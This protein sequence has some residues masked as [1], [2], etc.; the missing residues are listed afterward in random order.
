MLDKTRESDAGRQ[1]Q[2]AR[3]EQL[4]HATITAIAEHGLSNVT[5]S[6]VARKSA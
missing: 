3:R 2:E 4:I 6:K 5:L 1:P